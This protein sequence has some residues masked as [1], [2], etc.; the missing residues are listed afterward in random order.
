MAN[1]PTVSWDETEPT[2]ARAISEGDDRIRELKTQLREVIAEDHTMESSGQGENWGRH[3]TIRL[4]RRTSSP[5]K[6]TDIGQ[7]YAMQATINGDDFTELF[8]MDEDGNEVQL[9]RRGVTI[10][11]KAHFVHAETTESCAS[12]AYVQVPDMEVAAITVVSHEETQFL[13][14]FT[15]F[16]RSPY[17]AGGDVEGYFG[18]HVDGA[19]QT[20]SVARVYSASGNTAGM[21]VAICYVYE[22]DANEAIT[23]KVYWKLADSAKKLSVMHRMFRVVELRNE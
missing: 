22:H 21:S 19:V 10:G 16:C 1:K 11:P 17:A 8:Y 13:C 15:A 5:T 23:F 2:G 20:D 4:V 18:I 9:T 12:T 7:L 14:D 3:K 6:I